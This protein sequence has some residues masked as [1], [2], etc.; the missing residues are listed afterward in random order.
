[1]SWSRETKWRQGKMLSPESFQALA[2]IGEGLDLAMAISHDCDIANDNLDLEPSVEF[3]L[4]TL[5]DARDGNKEFGKNP[6]FLHL[7]HQH[8]DG[9]LIV[10]FHATRKISIQKNILSEHE[11]DDRFDFEDAGLAILR[12]WLAVRYKRQA[13]PDGFNE[14]LTPIAKFLEDQGKK[15]AAGIIGY[16]L[17]YQPRDVELAQ[18][19]T[20]EL[21]LYIV[22]ADDDLAYEDN[23]KK[24]VE[25]L[26]TKF[27]DLK[28][29]SADK[30]D[31]E[32]RDCEAYSEREFTLGD[33]RDNLQYRLEYLSHR[34]DPPGPVA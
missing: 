24:V 18:N 4:G 11:P 14:R 22:Y 3:V 28:K 32:L 23:A 9:P 27:S 20:Y 21:W 17:D 13:F 8:A 16:W 10:E 34:I 5:V 29:K 31:I 1:M 7:K 12:D 25:M 26:R 33:V 19:E 2:D 30:G 6:R 15:Y